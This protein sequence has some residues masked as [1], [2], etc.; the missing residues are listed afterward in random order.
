MWNEILTGNRVVVR[1]AN[2]SDLDA[3]RHIQEECHAASQWEPESYFS[4]DVHV[5]E[6]NHEIG[7]F[8][9]SRHVGEGEIEVLNLAVSPAFR[10][11]GIATTLL[12]AL[13]HS[14][15]FLEVRESNTPARSLYW[16]L[17]FRVVGKREEYYDDP[18]ESALVMRLSRKAE[19]VKF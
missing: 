1:P 11:Q 13:E 3:I 2:R 12:S 4:F 9:V 10:R 16:K 19:H 17:G 6:C 14:D 8:M 7:G 15:L 5:A 18:V